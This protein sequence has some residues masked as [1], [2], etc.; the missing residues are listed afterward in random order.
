[1]IENMIIRP[2]VTRDVKVIRELIDLYAPQRRL[3]KKETVSLFESVQEFT[4]AE[5]D[6]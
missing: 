6:G 2:A 1:M 3:L 4:V 5:V